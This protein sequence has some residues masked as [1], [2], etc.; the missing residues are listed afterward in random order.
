M[1]NWQYVFSYVME[2]A[3]TMMAYFMLMA[4][5][6]KTAEADRKKVKE[7]LGHEPTQENMWDYYELRQE[8]RNSRP[9]RQQESDRKNLRKLVFGD[10]ENSSETK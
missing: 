6:E 9:S 1:D 5:M 7:A 2:K 8:E 10:E 3:M 4:I